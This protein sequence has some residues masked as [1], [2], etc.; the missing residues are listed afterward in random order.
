MFDD[1][2]ELYLNKKKY[3]EQNFVYQNEQNNVNIHIVIDHLNHL[4][5]QSKLLLN[6][7]TNN[8]NLFHLM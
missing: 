7:Q 4:F 5:Y 8:I 3:I 2:Q 1:K 6:V